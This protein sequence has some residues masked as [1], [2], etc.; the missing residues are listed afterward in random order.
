[1]WPLFSLWGAFSSVWKAF[2]LF[3]RGLFWV[4]PPLRK[5]LWTPMDRTT[6][7]EQLQRFINNLWQHQQK[8]EFCDFTLTTNNTSIE[9]HK[10]V[11]SSAS[12]Y[13]SQLL[14]D[15]EHNTNIVDVTPLPEHILRTVV[16]FMYNSKYVIND[17]NVIELLKLSGNWNLDILAKLCV[18]YMNDNI[19]INNACRLYKFALDNGDQHKSQ[20]LNKFIRKHFT[21]LHEAGQLSE[22]SLKNFTT[23]IE[24]DD[25]NVKNEDVIFS[26]AVQIINQQTSVEDINNC[27]KLIRFPHTSGDFLVNVIRSHQ[28]MKEPPRDRYVSEAL[29][30]HVNKTST[31]E[32]KPPRYWGKS[33][34]YYIGYGICMY[35]YVSTAGNNECVKLMN[36]PEWVDGVSAV[37]SHRE[38][39]IIVG[40]ENG[41]TGDKR[42]L[43]LDMTNTTKVTQLPD[44][45]VTLWETGVVL[46]DNDV[47]V[48]G[49]FNCHELSSVY[50]LS[51]GSD[52]WQ[53]KK[54]LPHK[55]RSPLVIQHQQCIY[56]LGGSNNN[57]I[58]SSV[59]QYN[60]E[61]DTWKRCNDMP[62][63]CSNEEAGVVVHEDR[64]KVITVDKCLMYADDTDTWTVKQYNRL[65]HAVNAFVRREQIC[66]AVQDIGTYSMMS[67]DDVHNVWKTE[68]EKID[69]VWNTKSFC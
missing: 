22:L 54:S 65:G 40:G 11:L 51:F 14:F 10:L 30:Y 27:L 21:S 12:S 56:A 38:R 45:P 1:M 17:E 5:F 44:L 67:Y 50:Y 66:A 52:A 29:L 68:H 26:S 41:W 47:Y 2:L 62:V 57:G 20:M 58:Q 3:I 15:S 4:C 49:G 42:A 6:N 69:N 24:H 61:D 7:T 23:I 13:F 9:W 64:I 39:V 63:D 60:I 34:I 19:A 33:R 16:A 28:L 32:I 46:T 43:L 48:V 53:T 25:I 36:L 18:E 8:N 35:Q 37:A 31:R 55:L 59:S